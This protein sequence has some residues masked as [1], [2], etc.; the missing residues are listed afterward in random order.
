[1]Y[2]LKEFNNKS[3]A[4]NNNKGYYKKKEETNWK[5]D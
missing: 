3:N 5:R 2:G 1:M 4:R